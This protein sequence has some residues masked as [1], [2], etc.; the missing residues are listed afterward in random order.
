MHELEITVSM[1]LL[2]RTHHSIELTQVR[3]CISNLYTFRDRCDM[4]MG[5]APLLHL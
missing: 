3:Q 1:Y 4:Y 2:P 5:K